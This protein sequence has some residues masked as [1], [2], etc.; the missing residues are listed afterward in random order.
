M[1][2]LVSVS[3]MSKNESGKVL[4]STILDVGYWILD[5]GLKCT[6][7]SEPS[8]KRGEESYWMLDV[9][10]GAWIEMRVAVE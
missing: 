10:S 9:S 5:V 1:T 8:A 4:P 2:A 3:G 6:C 7:R